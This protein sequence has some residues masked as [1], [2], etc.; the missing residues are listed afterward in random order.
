MKKLDK[1][2]VLKRRFVSQGLGKTVTLY[3]DY[4]EAVFGLSKYILTEYAIAAIVLFSLNV[5]IYAM[6][7]S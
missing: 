7:C 1:S 4:E 6:L 5:V 2:F 3:F